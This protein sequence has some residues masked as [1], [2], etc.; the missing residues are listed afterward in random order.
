ML[1]IMAYFTGL[2]KFCTFLATRGI[3]TS[4]EEMTMVAGARMWENEIFT[5]YQMVAWENK[6]TAK[7]TWQLLQDYF[8]EK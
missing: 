2:D 3:L 4:I 8:T 5:E 6:P 7:Q 1:T